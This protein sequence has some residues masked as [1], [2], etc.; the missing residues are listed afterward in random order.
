M[1]KWIT[2]WPLGHGAKWGLCDAAL[3]V[4]IAAEGRCA[5]RLVADKQPITRIIL[6]I[7]RWAQTKLQKL[8]AVAA[9]LAALRPLDDLRQQSARAR[10]APP[11]PPPGSM[12][13]G[14]G[15]PKQKRGIPKHLRR[16][17]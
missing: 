17:A 10:V 15:K 7:P 6:Q 13:I 4:E 14:M 12:Q 1:A 2:N 8:P 11:S 16:A 3:A 9:G 5:V